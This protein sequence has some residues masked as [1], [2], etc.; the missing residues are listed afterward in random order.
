VLINEKSDVV[1]YEKLDVVVN[2]K[3]VVVANEKSDVLKMNQQLLIFKMICFN[4]IK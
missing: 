4:E 2:E 3:L 1:A